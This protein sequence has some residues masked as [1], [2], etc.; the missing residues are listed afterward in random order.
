MPAW[1][2]PR[3]SAVT[4]WPCSCSSV[5]TWDPTNPVAP[6]SVTFMA[7]SC[8]CPQGIESGISLVRDRSAGR[9]PER[10]EQDGDDRDGHD[11]PRGHAAARQQ[12]REAERDDHAGRQAPVVPDDEVVP[13]AQEREDVAH[14]GASTGSRVAPTATRRRRN[15]RTATI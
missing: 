2:S 5:S 13:E 10:A 7:A 3:T 6:V 11:P 9:P 8:S 14:A 1:A 15:A 12:R 4:S